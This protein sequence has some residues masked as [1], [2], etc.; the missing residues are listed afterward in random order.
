MTRERSGKTRTGLWDYPA[1]VLLLG[2]LA[3]GMLA[4]IG[5]LG[6]RQHATHL[7]SDSVRDLRLRAA[8]AHLW[9]EEGLTDGEAAKLQRAWTEFAEAI[10]LSQVLLN[11]G[12]S[13]RGE[14]VPPLT[15]PALRKLVENLTRLLTTLSEG[16]RERIEKR[17]GVASSLNL[18]DNVIFDDFQNLAA[19]LEKIVEENEVADH[20]KSLRLIY[21]MLAVWSCVLGV[22]IFGLVRH[23]RRRRQTEN[24]LR[25]SEER[26]AAIIGTA[27]DA[28]ITLDE[29]QRV[30]LFN[31][32]AEKIFGCPASEAIGLPLDRFI[33]ERFR[34]V[35]RGHI[36][37]YA[38][39]GVS[40][41]S[42]YSPK[43]LSAQRAD[44][45]EF[46]IEAT[47]SQA[48]VGGQKLLTVILRDLT[49]RKQAEEMVKLYTQAK[50]RD[51]HKTQFIYNLS[52][53]LRTP[54]TTIREGVSQVIDGILGATT[55]E[56]REFLS[57]VLDDIDR[58]ARII[59]DLLD[60]AKIETGRFDLWLENVNVVA[61]AQQAARLFEPKAR[62]KGLS[63]RT[64]F[65][66]PEIE[67]YADPDKI[68]QVFANLLG[69]AL[70]FT[71]H[72]EVTL[73][74]DD[75]GEQASCA[76]R[77]TGRGIAPEDM[78][79]VFEKYYQVGMKPGPGGQGTGLGLAIAKGIVESHGGKIWARSELG[80][81][82]A[83][84]FV[85]PKK[86][87]QN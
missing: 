26:F 1:G 84:T 80:V 67:V 50:A 19:N 36:H 8:T 13:E 65:A 56:Q 76:V 74:V 42:M 81:G 25:T 45:Q 6:L 69:N 38:E 10:R 51:E 3:L 31:A 44:G 24:D 47:I 59:N 63:I 49:E 72:G 39:T 87:V 71:L 60:I 78:P 28:I 58:L 46:P 61:I 54:L 73:R 32:A 85:L 27:M 52:H 17:A 62:S 79:K 41:R 16:A 4:W 22:S 9:L 15:A 35:H 66:K 64:D 23:E 12:A 86:S 37:T 30:V 40:S 20:A 11:G 34:Q 29:S 5:Q 57:I 83:F 14:L 48:K 33:P 7:T 68:A 70:K 82:S 43:E 2:M 53:E 18:R 21:G 77:D 55:P 75:L